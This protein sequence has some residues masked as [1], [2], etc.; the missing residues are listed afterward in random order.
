MASRMW[1][2]VLRAFLVLASGAAAY[3]N[4][5]APDRSSTGHHSLH[6][7]SAGPVVPV[8]SEIQ[9]LRSGALVRRGEFGP[10]MGSRVLEV[11]LECSD[12]GLTI[13]QAQSIRKQLLIRKA[14]KA[15]RRL[16][17]ERV[18]QR[19][20]RKFDRQQT[21]LLDLAQQ[22]GVADLRLRT[23]RRMG[24]GFGSFTHWATVWPIL[25]TKG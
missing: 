14:Q 7:P 17:N 16:K 24:A 11:E 13:D 20:S 23:P 18:L 3:T 22:H 5:P 9:L 6:W 2:C 21:P 4:Y 19:I 12:S 8:T 15:S 10:L 1:R 25:R